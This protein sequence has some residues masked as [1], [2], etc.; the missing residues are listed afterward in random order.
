MTATTRSLILFILCLFGALPLH[1]SASALFDQKPA[2][3]EE[4]EALISKYTKLIEQEPDKA[5]HYVG[6]GTQYF[7]MRD[8]D[9]AIADYDRALK[10]DDAQDMAYYGRGLAQS[11]AGWIEEGIEDLSV[12][13]KRHPDDSRAYTKRGVRY[14]WLGDQDS[15]KKD[16]EEAVRLDPFNAEAHD[17]LGVIYA[18]RGQYKEAADH[19]LTTLEIDPTYQK[20]YHNMAMISF[21]TDKDVL[22]LGFVNSS[23]RLVPHDKDSLMLKS[24]ILEAMG[25]EDEARA[26]REEAEFLPEGNWSEHVPLR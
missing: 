13:I 22:A 21:L 7:F 24:K 3:A 19:F 11:R 2:T 26:L 25:K 17:D 8:T 12:Y 20:A 18:Y 15:A 1:A 6:R 16:L 14:I 23:L 9:K 10:L 4:A 5:E